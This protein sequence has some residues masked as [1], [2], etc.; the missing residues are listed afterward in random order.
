M[1]P[2]AFGRHRNKFVESEIKIDVRY[3]DI[4]K[5]LMQDVTVETRHD[6]EKGTFDFLA[7]PRQAGRLPG[8]IVM[9][10]I[11]GVNEQIKTV[12]IR[13]AK[14]GYVV[15]AVDLFHGD[16]TN[17]PKV[18]KEFLDRF[19]PEQDMELIQQRFEK[20]RRQHYV[21]RD[22]IG[23][24]GF[25]SGGYYALLA[26]AQIK[27]LKSAVAFY[28]RFPEDII[29]AVKNIGCPVMCFA[30]GKGKDIY[31]EN[32]YEL[33]RV[34]EQAGKKAS[35]HIYENAKPPFF[36]DMHLDSYE[37]VSAMDAWQ[38]MSA[39]LSG[40][41]QDAEIEAHPKT[42]RYFG[43]IG[44]KFRGLIDDAMGKEEDENN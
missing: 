3:L 39:F 42:T 5:N 24:L 12:C 8:I 43:N 40:N 16:V 28:G 26:A 30:G 20:L 23:I 19:S 2:S 35:F 11:W 41:F 4:F 7:K 25:L 22:R 21:V 32:V 44:G 15:L 34:F 13:L 17:I 33:K 1:E 38:K 37:P 18:A 10:D 27:T 29:P 14:L 36:D 6:F 31:Q 9:H